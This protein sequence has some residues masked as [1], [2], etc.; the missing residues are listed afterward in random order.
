MREPIPSIPPLPPTIDPS[1]APLTTALTK[2]NSAIA[3][4]REQAATFPYQSILIDR[5][6]LIDAMASCDMSG[7]QATPKDV[8]AASLL[9]ISRRTG[10]AK[11]VLTHRSTLKRGFDRLAYDNQTISNKT[12]I[13][14][15]RSAVPT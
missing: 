9:A 5:I 10:P 11:D 6:G 14:M 7:I 1:Y 2:A 12:L 8:Y 15:Y 3:H 13:E 4:L